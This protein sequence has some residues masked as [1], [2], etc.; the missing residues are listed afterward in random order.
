MNATGSVYVSGYTRAPYGAGPGVSRFSLAPDGAVGTRLA[1]GSGAVNPSFAVLDG[2]A[3]LAVEELPEGRIAVFDPWTLDLRGRAP[4][5]GSDPCHLLLL[6]PSV[7]AANYSSG[8]AS[9]T[10]LAAIVGTALPGGTTPEPPVL[11]SHPGSGP[12]GGRQA[13]SHAHQVTATPWGTVL[14]SDLGADRVDEYSAR[15]LVRLGSA[16]LPPGTGP[17]HVAIK[18]EFLLVAGELDGHVHVLRR[19]EVDPHDGAGH[20]WKWL[21]RTPLA[22]SA[23]EIAGAR[24]FAPSHI[25]LSADGTRLYA[26]VRGPDTLVV[27][28]VA[29]LDPAGPAAPAVLAEVACG[30][31][32]PRHFAVGNNKMY[33]ANQLSNN[34]AVFDL[35]GSGLPGPA[36]VQSVDF[37][38]PTCV[39]LG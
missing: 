3:L 32:W 23:A 8:T 22:A 33:V 34:I 20:F 1:T 13:G 19:S 29:G 35:D 28:D 27:L 16:E 4:S 5:G 39:V 21:F 12:V 37:G 7:W 10:P 25:R 6:R 14:V 17:R 2:G 9:V 18:G 11:L 31:S 24:D 30:G 38:S 15:S 36:P 26:A